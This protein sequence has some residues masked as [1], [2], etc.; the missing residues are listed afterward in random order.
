MG[1]GVT[2]PT[3]NVLLGSIK[4][5]S[6]VRNTHGFREG[7]GIRKEKELDIETPWAPWFQQ[8]RDRSSALKA[9]L[10]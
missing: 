1:P 4:I 2:E 9:G 3:E 5:G 7:E 10:L 6:W 8:A